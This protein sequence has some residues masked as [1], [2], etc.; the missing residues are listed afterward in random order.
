MR[1][2]VR[3]R[4]RHDPPRGPRRVLRLRRAARR[5][6]AARATGHR[7]GGV[8]LAASYE[9]RAFGV[10]S[11]W[12]ARALA[13][14][15]RSIVV[16]R[17]QAYVEASRAVFAIFDRTSPVVE[18]ISI[19]EAFLDVRG[20]SGSSALP[21]RSRGSC[22]ATCARR[23]G[24]RSRRRG[25]TKSWRRSRAA[26]PSPTA[27]WWC[28]PRRARLSAPAA[29]GAAVGRRRRPP[30][31]SSTAT[32]SYG[33]ADSPRR[34][35]R[36]VAMLGRGRRPPSA[37]RSH[38]RDPAGARRPRPALVRRA[39]GARAAGRAARGLDAVLVG[40]GGPCHPA[41]AAAG[42][43]GRTVVLRLRFDDFIR[44][45]RRA[46]CADA[47]VRAVLAVAR[48]LLEEARP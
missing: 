41:H 2:C 34:R 5:S 20:W 48:R 22:G 16:P 38:N 36:L 14:C 12:A 42:R 37:T 28:P 1:T 21:T 24:C 7:R 32:A 27:C 15:A 30:A 23:S 13:G 44:A 11:A 9:A 40:A 17:W 46:R 26:W 35:A 4:R 25:H 47:S 3:V 10:R 39:V 19:D 6:A 45:T 8:V 29:G 31:R 18:C 33:G 43:A